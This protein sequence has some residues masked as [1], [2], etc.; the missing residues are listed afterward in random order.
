MT[1]FGMWLR[2][3]KFLFFLLFLVVASWGGYEWRRNLFVYHWSEQERKQYLEA[4]V[5]ETAFQEKEFLAVLAQLA[6]LAERHAENT[7]PERELFIGEPKEEG[8]R[9]Q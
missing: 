9:P 3:Y 1:L 2:H 8:A 6:S 4:T 5:K 7:V